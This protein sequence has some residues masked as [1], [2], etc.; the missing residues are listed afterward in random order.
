MENHTK[1]LNTAQENAKKFSTKYN[2]KL[3]ANVAIKVELN[4]DNITQGINAALLPV[5]ARNLLEHID[6]LKR[7]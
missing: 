5:E 4:T 7:E 3:D 2:Q 1:L 6:N